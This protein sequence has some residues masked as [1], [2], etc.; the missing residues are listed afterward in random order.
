M[1][2]IDAYEVE[3]NIEISFFLPKKKGEFI[4]VIGNG[5]LHTEVWAEQE[6]YEVPFGLRTTCLGCHHE[7]F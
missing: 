4:V 1:Y 3:I 7:L 6:I 2:N 5:L